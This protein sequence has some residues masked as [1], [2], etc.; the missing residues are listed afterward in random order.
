MTLEQTVPVLPAATL[1]GD[2]N[3]TQPWEL[4]STTRTAWGDIRTWVDGAD[5][6]EYLAAGKVS[7]HPDRWTWV[8]PHWFG[9]ATIAVHKV[10]SYASPPTWCAVGKEVRIRHLLPDGVTY[11]TDPRSEWRGKVARVVD[12]DAKTTVLECTGWYQIPDWFVQGPHGGGAATE[13]GTVWAAGLAASSRPQYPWGSDPSAPTTG[14]TTT[15]HGDWRTVLEFLSAI[16]AALPLW[17][18]RPADS[19]YTPSFVNTATSPGQSFTLR[20]GNYVDVELVSD[21]R[22]AVNVVYVTGFSNGKPWELKTVD[23]T[24]GSVRHAPIAAL[25]TVNTLWWNDTTGDI[26]VDATSFDPAVPRIEAHWQLPAGMTYTDA[27]AVADEFVAAVSTPGL[28][29]HLGLSASPAEMHLLDLRPDD[30]CTYEGYRGS[31]RTLY[32]GEVAFDWNG[33]TP[34]AD[35]AVDS[36]GRDLATIEAILDGDLEAA[37]NP[38]ARVQ[39]G[40]MEGQTDGRL[41]KWSTEAGSGTVPNDSTNGRRH[42]D[43]T[44][45]WTVTGNQ[46]NE[47]IF[48]AAEQGSIKSLELVVSDDGTVGPTVGWEFVAIITDRT[49]ALPP[50]PDSP[51]P[52][53]PMAQD[54]MDQAIDDPTLGAQQSWGGNFLSGDG[55]T[56]V[57]NPMGYG[58]IAYK[59]KAMGADLT[60]LLVDQSSWPFSHEDTSAAPGAGSLVLYVFPI[61]AGTAECY[62]E[63]VPGPEPT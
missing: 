47:Y 48:P 63:T 16:G 29:G 59:W 40:R 24:D 39:A 19:T 55:A 43:G 15:Q 4:T 44:S 49:V 28:T 45:T 27:K 14:E 18:W 8:K 2:G 54:A 36:G 7:V 10:R 9:D 33:G 56:Y 22:A 20:H 17:T 50:D 53:D 13:I 51:L 21:L 26:D 57:E 42:K 38:F 25:T 37:T 1:D 52:V 23:P 6:T 12:G 60:G 62:M 46:W 61:G 3:P 58:N 35:L 32:V 34:T 30:I 41:A 31:D 5:R 11:N